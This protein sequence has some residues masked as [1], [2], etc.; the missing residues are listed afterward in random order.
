MLFSKSP[1][2]I[3]TDFYK[4]ERKYMSAG[5]SAGGASFDAMAATLAPDVVLHQTP[6][7][8]FG[9]EYV[10]H[11][12][13]RVWAD[14]MSAIFDKVDARSPVFFERDDTVVIVC[15]LVTRIRATGEEMSLPMVQVVRVKSDK[16]TE[17]RPFYWNVSA[18]VAAA[19]SKA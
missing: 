14:A 3:L 12:R 16:I 19:Q 2:D 15:T 17:F 11:E 13:D 9:G 4:A 5:G 18:Y 7:L 6:D 8:P 1:K 10:G